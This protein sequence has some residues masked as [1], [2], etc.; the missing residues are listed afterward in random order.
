MVLIYSV[1]HMQNNLTYKEE[2]GSRPYPPPYPR[3]RPCSLGGQRVLE[4]EKGPWL[5]GW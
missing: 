2:M 1:F 3:A 5:G 4:L